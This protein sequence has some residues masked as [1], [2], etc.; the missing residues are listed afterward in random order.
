[1]QCRYE[2]AFGGLLL[3]MEGAYADL[4]VNEVHRVLH[5]V[6]KTQALELMVRTVLT[7]YL[8]QHDCSHC[9]ASIVMAASLSRLKDQSR[10]VCMDVVIQ[11]MCEDRHFD[12]K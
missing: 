12:V 11:I 6:S 1:M 9:S 3:T 7:A 4:M 10:W 5:V 2:K 8:Q